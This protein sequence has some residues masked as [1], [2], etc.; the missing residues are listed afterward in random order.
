MMTPG[1]SN[2]KVTDRR[3]I[4]NVIPWSRPDFTFYH[5]LIHC[6][7]VDFPDELEA[8]HDGVEIFTV[9]G[10]TGFVEIMEVNFRHIKWVCR[11]KCNGACAV[12]CVRFHYKPCQDIVLGGKVWVGSVL[13]VTLVVALEESWQ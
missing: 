8:F 7:L 12:F 10:V 4:L 6:N 5:A 1:F 11:A 3:V 2:Y 9:T 13:R